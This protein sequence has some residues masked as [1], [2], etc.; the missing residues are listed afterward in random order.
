MLE[1]LYTTKMSMEKKLLQNRF[2]KIRS[3]SGRISKLMSLIML[4]VILTAMICVTVILAA[5][6]NIDEFTMSEKEFSDYI[7]RPIGAVM[8]DI[9]YADGSKTVFHHGEGLFIIHR[10]D[11]SLENK[12]SSELDLVINLKKL[13]IAYA[14]QGSSVLDIKISKDG[15]YAYLS[16][17]GSANEIKNFDNYIIALDTGFVKKGVIPEN[18]ELFTGTADTLKEV[19]NPVGWYSN[20][21]ITSEDKIYYLTSETSTINGIQLITH[22]KNSGEIEHRYIFGDN[23]VSEVSQITEETSANKSYIDNSEEAVKAFFDA[24]DKSDFKT[25]K[26]LVTNEFAAAGYISNDEMC[27]GMTRATPETYSE[28]NIDVFLNH[29]LSEKTNER[30]TLSEKDIALLKEKSDEIAVYTVIVTA[31][32]STQPPFKRFLNIICKKQRDGSWLVHKLI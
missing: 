7:N 20:N 16:S 2:L 11:Y 12:L 26:T 19:Q 31:Q 4:T 5:N 8:A 3:K 14:Q 1:N 9:C 29:Y 22:N 32:E 30:L 25:M 24:F 28:T 13:N 10:Q 23:F 21:C 17:I 27:Y 15:Q 6:F 18:T